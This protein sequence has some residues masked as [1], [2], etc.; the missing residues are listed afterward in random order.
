[1]ARR[2]SDTGHREAVSA[3]TSI[4]EGVDYSFDR[5][6]GAAL[7]KAGKAFAMRYIAHPAGAPNLTTTE[8]ADLH[9]HDISVG[10][11]L[12]RGRDRVLGGS[13]AGVT[14]AKLAKGIM[15]ALGFPDDRPV[16]FAVD[17]N[18]QAAQQY[19]ID[20]YMSGAGSILGVERVG[21]Y[22]SYSVVNRCFRSGVVRWGWQTYAWSSGNVSPF[23]HVLQYNN[24]ERINN[25]AVDLDRSLRADFGQWPVLP[26]TDT[27]AVLFPIRFPGNG[28]AGTVSIDANVELFKL[29]DGSINDDHPALGPLPA[30]SALHVLNADGVTPD[31][32]DTPG[33][34]FNGPSG[35]PYWVRAKQAAFIDG[36]ADDI[37]ALKAQV[38]ALQ[39]QVNGLPDAIQAAIAADRAKAKVVWA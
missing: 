25:A 16:Y 9:G 32:N 6:G 2:L 5:P 27:E 10:V 23:A 21:V 13:A 22:G 11:V 15:A 8:I 14:D 18:A 7:A 12:E 38:A 24:G 3:A 17:F 36:D 1:M 19:L 20:A 29:A 34:V 39:A 35:T 33:F 31:P 26:E 37:A 30:Y 4:L 28:R